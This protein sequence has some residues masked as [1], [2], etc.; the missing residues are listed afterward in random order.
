M[1]PWD[2]PAPPG[3]QTPC[4][5]KLMDPRPS[6]CRPWMAGP[7]D[8]HSMLRS[9]L[10]TTLEIFRGS[11]KER[12]AFFL[13]LHAFT[14]RLKAGVFWSWMQHIALTRPWKAGRTLRVRSEPLAACNLGSRAHSARG[15]LSLPHWHQVRKTGRKSPRIEAFQ[16]EPNPK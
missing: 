10:E 13:L 8:Y 14:P 16:Q 2:H 4:L 11:V 15:S 6:P 9:S 12:Q 1:S 7:A 3:T 5:V